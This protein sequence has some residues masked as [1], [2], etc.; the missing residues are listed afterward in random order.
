MAISGGRNFDTTI[1]FNQHW[2]ENNIL[3]NKY[4]ALGLEDGLFDFEA[5]MSLSITQNNA[6]DYGQQQIGNWIQQVVSPE[7][8]L[9]NNTFS[10]FATRIA[11]DFH[12]NAIQSKLNLSHEYVNQSYFT[13]ANPFL[14]TGL[15]KLEAG[16]NTQLKKWETEFETGI[17][18]NLFFPD[19][20]SS[21]TTGI[22]QYKALINTN[23]T[24]DINVLINYYPN[25]IILNK[26]K[27]IVT[28]TIGAVTY[29]FSIKEFPTTG[30]LTYVNTSSVIN[31]IEFSENNFVSNAVMLLCNTMFSKNFSTGLQMQ[32]N[33]VNSDTAFSSLSFGQSISAIIKEKVQLNGNYSIPVYSNLSDFI[34][35]N[36]SASYLFNKVSIGA[37]LMQME[38]NVLNYGLSTPTQVLWGNIFCSFI[39]NKQQ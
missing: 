39:L 38:Y 12:L 37:G 30:I 16:V 34:S 33:E 3:F 18:Y 22:L 31:S 1:A 9:V 5:A 23:P 13:A 15:Q 10:G 19:K 21:M 32:F 36:L 28:S 6:F 8:S 27:T 29:K 11:T 4:Q 17:V 14:L 20:V 35:F 24:E 26:E 2:D 7:G 25:V